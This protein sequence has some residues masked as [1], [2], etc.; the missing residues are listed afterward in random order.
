MATKTK[1]EV[2]EE[3]NGKD[4]RSPLLDTAQSPAGRDWRR[5][6]GTRRN[7]GF[8]QQAGGAR[9]DC[10]KRWAQIG[11]GS[12]GQTQERRRKGRRRVI[13]ASGRNLGPHECPDEERYRGSWRQDCL[14]HQEG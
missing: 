8:R 11:P 7:R 10:G 14:A 6:T 1:P 2:V 5:R 13:Q 3:T 9:R 4:E 12:D